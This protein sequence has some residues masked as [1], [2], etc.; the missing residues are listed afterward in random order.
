[1]NW[2]Q[3]IAQDSVIVNH[4]LLYL[5]HDRN[6]IFII[7]YILKNMLEIYVRNSRMISVT[8]RQELQLLSSTIQIQPLWY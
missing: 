7:L 4:L 5:C 8:T 1:M 2:Q 3:C 6:D